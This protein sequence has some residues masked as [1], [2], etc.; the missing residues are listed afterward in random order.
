MDVSLVLAFAVIG[1]ALAAEPIVNC[2]AP[3]SPEH[4]QAF[5]Y[6]DGSIVKYVC[7]PGYV[8]LGRELVRCLDGQW[9]DP[10]PMCVET[11]KSSDQAGEDLSGKNALPPVFPTRP[12]FSWG[13]DSENKDSDTEKN[14]TAEEMP[15]SDEARM[16][17]VIYPRRRGRVITRYR[18]AR[19]HSATE[20]EEEEK[21]RSQREEK[22]TSTTI[23][24]ESP[25]S[26]VYV[27]RTVSPGKITKQEQALNQQ[28]RTAAVHMRV[29]NTDNGDHL[30]IVALPRAAVSQD[31]KGHQAEE[32]L[33]HM[34]YL[35]NYNY[36]RQASLVE[37]RS[38]TPVVMTLS[39]SQINWINSLHPDLRDQY[40]KDLYVMRAEEAVEG[41]R[42][43]AFLRR[44]DDTY[45]LY[46]A[47][48]HLRQ[49]VSLV[50]QDPV[51]TYDYS[52][53]QA[54]SSFVRAP[55][56]PNAHVARYDRRQNPNPPNNHYLSAVY[57]CDPEFTMLD[58]RFT[59]L[60]CSRGQWV[61]HEPICVPRA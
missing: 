10:L 1:F 25:P 11:D 49:P 4:G 51:R 5:L 19:L 55:K 16:R 30:Q 50:L 42:A 38:G 43:Q 18:T 32:T 59:E 57:R 47:P 33:R 12:L 41:A 34:Y 23:H 2:P 3:R 17:M 56:L 35:A 24:L 27:R 58:P 20:L 39:E 6:Q 21:K 36:P 13:S 61:G 29:D 9:E 28:Y 53:N 7:E 48:V 52:C 22:K 8:L 44:Y 37:Y 45:N 31:D 60:Y 54:H 14:S 46:Y 26:V 15:M 40:L